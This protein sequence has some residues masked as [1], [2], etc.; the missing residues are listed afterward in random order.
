MRFLELGELGLD[1]DAGGDGE[2]ADPVTHAGLFR[3][4][5]VGQAEIGTAG[6]LV[7]L[8]A[9]A[10]QHRAVGQFNVV[11]DAIRFEESDH[12]ARGQP[13]F[14][15]DLLQHLLRVAKQFARLRT[16]DCIV[17]DLRI[18]ARQFPRV[19]ER[20]PVDALD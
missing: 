11:A 8:L 18:V 14:G 12:T 2:C 20:R 17:E 16:D 3:R 19:E 1:A 10:V 4:D 9:Q 6:R 5:E 15:D 13:F 7:G